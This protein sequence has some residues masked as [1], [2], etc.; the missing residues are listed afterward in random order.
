[1]M[2]QMRAATTLVQLPKTPAT[3]L[4]RVLAT[5]DRWV[6]TPAI[7]WTNRAASIPAL[8]RKTRAMVRVPAFP[9]LL[10]LRKAPAMT[11]P[12]ASVTPAQSGQT[13]AMALR[14]AS[15]RATQ[16]DPDSVTPLSCVALAELVPTLRGYRIL[17]GA[18]RTM[19]RQSDQPNY[20]IGV[21]THHS[22]S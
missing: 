17:V 6:L 12:P 10:Q 13:P 21:D 15:A 5:K 4:R 19:A 3:A 9:T 1:V 16:S 7:L 11:L 18:Y 8:S 2:V 22:D 20:R 14:R